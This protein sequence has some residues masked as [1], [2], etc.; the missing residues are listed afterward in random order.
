MFGSLHFS[1]AHGVLPWPPL[2]SFHC[3][4]AVTS[5]M[6]SLFP[7]TVSSVLTGASHNVS[8]VLFSIT[9]FSS[10]DHSHHFWLTSNVFS[11]AN[12]QCTYSAVILCPLM[13]SVFANSSHPSAM[14][15]IVSG[16]FLHI[17]RVSSL[18]FFIILFW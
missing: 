16:P 7:F 18:S 12:V 15:C 13:T 11:F 3:N 2:F 6:S 4:P 10:E 5:T 17:Q 14:R 1:V 8:V 9:P